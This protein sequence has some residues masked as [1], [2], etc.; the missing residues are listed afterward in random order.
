MSESLSEEEMRQ[1]LFGSAQSAP[2]LKAT[3]APIP[4]P[5]TRSTTPPIVR[6][7]SGSSRLRVTLHVSKVFEGEVEVFI[8]DVN[9]L[10]TLLAQQEAMAAA[11]KKKYKYL[12]VV[13]VKTI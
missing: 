10:S 12:E 3:A 7:T 2:A 8:H 1:A 4:Q 9:T 11:R 6:P 13:S 5:R